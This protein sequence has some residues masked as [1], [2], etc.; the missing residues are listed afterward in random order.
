MQYM[1]KESFLNQFH[2]HIDRLTT[3]ISFYFFRSR[4]SD[5]CPTNHGYFNLPA[6]NRLKHHPHFHG[7]LVARFLLL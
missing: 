7:C 3:K 5:Y 6:P 1:L 4:D 2:S